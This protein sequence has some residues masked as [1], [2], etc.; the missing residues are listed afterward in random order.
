M[1]D[2][3]AIFKA[4]DIRGTY[5]DQ[6][7]ESVARAVGNAVVDFVGADRVLVG[8]DARPSGGAL[9]R[10][11][12]EGAT[13]AGADVVDLG[14]ASTDLVYFAA[15]HLDAPAAMFTAS[16]NPAQYQG[17]K[18]CGRGATPIGEETGLRDIKAAVGRGTFDEAPTPGRVE[19]RDLLPEFVDHVHSFV[20]TEILAPL[21][22]AVDTANG[23]GGLVVPAVL[24]G[25]PFHCSFLYLELDGT[26]PNHPADPIQPENL[27]DLQRLVVE[28][29]ADVGLAFDGDADRVFLVD[30]QAQ[31]LSGSLTT[32]LVARSILERLG[33]DAPPD[34][35]VVV[36]NLIC[37]KAVP[38][39]VREL[40]G[41]PVR[42]A[43][44][45]LL[46]Q[47]GHGRDGRDLR[48]RALRPL[49]L[50][51]QLPRRLRADRRT[52]RARGALRAAV[53]LSE[54]RTSLER[55]A[56]SGEINRRIDDPG[57]SIEKVAAAYTD[58]E[59]DRLDGLTVDLG[60]WW[61][62][63]RSEQHRAAP[64]ARPRG[65][66]PRRV[67]RASRR[68]ARDRRRRGRLTATAQLAR[69]RRHPRVAL[70]P[71][72]LEILACPGG[73]GPAALL[74]VGVVALQPAPQASVRRARRHPDHA[75]RRS[76]DRRRCR[77]RPSARQGERGRD[78]ADLRHPHVASR[79]SRDRE[80]TARRAALRTVA[81][82][83]R[84]VGPRANGPQGGAAYRGAEG[85][86]HGD[87]QPRVRRRRHP[88][89]PSSSTAR[90]GS[91]HR[92]TWRASR[93]ADGIDAVVVLGM[94]GSAIA[95]TC[96]RQWD[97]RS[98]CR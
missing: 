15:G 78:P 77:A 97:R 98:Q 52:R 92:S 91:R 25:L 96:S 82:R 67:R 86:S 5:P 10:T 62:N 32:T 81:P 38:E 9:V 51:R 54:L 2:L 58:A 47:A 70:D 71:Q 28:D 46:H 19:R 21:R 79:D 63:L 11:F 24:E 22:V 85:A 14:L 50:S 33:P 59:Q 72:L 26:F 35:R 45:A 42:H 18:L 44:R 93:P 36:H 13:A 64:A 34:D 55:Y 30:D 83:E 12:T 73:Q 37:S 16:H 48:G 29:G 31:P 87:G 76:G 89:S 60:D 7:D 6:I 20:D 66:G 61:F 80:R 39:I 23:I 49:L 75:H 3:D 27:R 53:P 90:T 41:T 65:R 95:G 88:A 74:R 68:G 40:G 1:P 94:G 57:A 4:Y 84:A 56:D 17:I 8:R 69:T 43:R